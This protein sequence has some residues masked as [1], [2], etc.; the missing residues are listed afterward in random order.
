MQAIQTR[1][2]PATQTLPARVKAS[3]DA[4]E[5]VI[6]ASDAPS[7]HDRAYVCLS[8]H[9]TERLAPLPPSPAFDDYPT[10]S[11]I[12]AEGVRVRVLKDGQLVQEVRSANAAFAFLAG[13]Q[14]QS[15]SYALTHGG[16]SCEAVPAEVAV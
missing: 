5:V 9:G 12:P 16:W 10:L 1:I 2:L 6:S 13:I 14:G 3:C 7:P 8:K 15:V 11:N 4:G